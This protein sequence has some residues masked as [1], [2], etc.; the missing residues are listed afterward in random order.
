MQGKWLG[1]KFTNNL[2]L[3]F[4]HNLKLNSPHNLSLKSTPNLNCV[5]HI[6]SS[7]THLYTCTQV[8]GNQVAHDLHHS[9][10][11][12]KDS[13]QLIISSNS[14]RLLNIIGQGTFTVCV[15]LF[16]LTCCCWGAK[17]ST[18]VFHVEISENLFSCIKDIWSQHQG[19]YRPKPWIVSL[20]R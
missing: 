3:K 12:S 19:S 10:P 14:I 7:C 9:Y 11:D 13:S 2:S 16:H 8:P 17:L 5:L 20:P 15:S 18:V 6:V 4:T 1:L